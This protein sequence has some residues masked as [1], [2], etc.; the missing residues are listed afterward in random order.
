[1]NPHW[2]L[3]DRQ[4]LFTCAQLGN[5]NSKR[6]FLKIL[7][8]GAIHFEAL[9]NCDYYDFEKKLIDHRYGRR[10]DENSRSDQHVKEI[11][12]AGY[13]KMRQL[14]PTDMKTFTTKAILTWNPD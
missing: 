14:T 4:L 10:L 8:H 11:L 6:R 5:D 9:Y 13:D 1:M 7:Q 12:R 3:A 2:R